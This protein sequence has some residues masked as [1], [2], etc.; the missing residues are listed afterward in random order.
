MNQHLNPEQRFLFFVQKM[1]RKPLTIFMRFCTAI[2]NGGLIWIFFSLAFLAKKGYRKNG[3]ILLLVLALTAFI[4]NLMI[5]PL[6]SRQRPYERFEDHDPLI[7]EPFGSSFPS[8]H[9]ATSFAC[10]VT[11]LYLGLPFAWLGFILAACIALSRIYLFVHF[12]TDVLFGIAAGSLLGLVITHFALQH[13]V[14]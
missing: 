10:A 13:F 5:K 11:M 6:F 3:F 1:H 8:G 7:K 4:I 9:S 12:P 2:G 14:F